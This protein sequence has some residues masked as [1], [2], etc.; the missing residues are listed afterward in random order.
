MEAQAALTTSHFDLGMFGP[1]RT[2]MEPMNTGVT[3]RTSFI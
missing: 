3:C 1:G 2:A